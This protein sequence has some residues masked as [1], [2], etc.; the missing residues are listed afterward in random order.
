M[1]VVKSTWFRKIQSEHGNFEIYPDKGCEIYTFNDF[2]SKLLIIR[3]NT[4]AQRKSGKPYKPK[5]FV[6]NPKTGELLNRKDYEPYF[7]YESFSLRSKDGKWETTVQR[8]VDENGEDF[9][10][11][12]I[13]NLETNEKLKPA[14]GVAF[15]QSKYETWIDRYHE[16]LERRKKLQAKLTLNQHFEKSKKEL[17]TNDSIIKYTSDKTVFHLIYNGVNFQLKSK[18]E[19][20]NR[21]FKWEN[22]NYIEQEFITIEEF[23]KF[24]TKDK[25]WFKNLNP[26]REKVGTDKLIAKTII[27]YHNTFVQNEFET[28][29]YR[30]LHKWINTVFTD[31]IKR[32]EYKQYCV[33]CKKSTFYNARYPKYICGDCVE[34]LTDMEGRKVEYFNTELLGHGCQGYYVGTE[35]REKYNSTICYIK[36]RKFYAEEARFGGIVIQLKE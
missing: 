26:V 31:S 13:V 3:E 21:D 10:E 14:V 36:D 29:D 8:K 35:Q 23:W 30:I 24:I 19:Q 16:E 12:Q 18:D 22:V 27:K 5:M 2:E 11:E 6:L 1:K 9:I 20:L 17:K 28:E 7:N 15:R 32:S 34:L 4:L 33:N 25:N